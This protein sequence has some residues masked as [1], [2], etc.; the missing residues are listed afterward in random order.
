V[1]AATAARAEGARGDL[2]ALRRAAE[3]ARPVTLAGVRALPVSPA[4]ATLLPEGIRR[5]AV[6]SVASTG[7]GAT[8]L[9]LA[10]G[11]AASH[12]G[13]WAAVVGHPALGLQAA[14]ELGIDH[15]RLLVVPAVPPASWATVVAALLDGVDL[16]YARPPRGGVSAGDARRL[17]ARVRE[18]EAVL[19]PVG[20]TWPLAADLRL[21]VGPSTWTR[22]GGRLVARRAEVVASGRGVY[23]R[24]RRAELWLPGPDGRV[25]EA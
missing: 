13:S 4:L 24:E 5:G 6:V 18:R 14:A 12:E 7:P 3:L 16:V 9:A 15:G 10:L 20:G 19:V 8:S 1:G 23:A 11:A 2:H 17:A 25:A 22:G 21:A